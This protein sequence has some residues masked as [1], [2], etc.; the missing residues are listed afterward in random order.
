M[1]MEEK[2]LEFK[3]A[4]FGYP[5]CFNHDCALRETC[6]HYHVGLLAPADRLTGPAVYPSAW[7]DGACR[8]Y[9]EKK[10]VKLAWGFSQLYK[11][12]TKG[13]TADARGSLRAHLGSGMSAYYRYHYGE[14]L[15][16]PAQQ[17][18]VRDIIVRYGG[19]K[20][21][22]FDHYVLQYDFS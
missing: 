7:K 3:D 17:E 16:T 9:R 5:L 18:E 2:K 22:Q 4:P 14:R 20:D 19:S 15:L 6:M 11:G 8:Y 12:M 21:V 13:Q 10:L 1:S